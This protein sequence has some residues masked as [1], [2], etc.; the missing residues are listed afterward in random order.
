[1]ASRRVELRAPPPGS[2]FG[3]K[4]PNSVLKAD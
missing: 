3:A 1:M 2:V 4:A